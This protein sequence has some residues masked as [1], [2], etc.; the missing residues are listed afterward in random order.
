MTLL[1]TAEDRFS[2]AQA[3]GPLYTVY[4]RV[5]TGP[6][7][8]LADPVQ[9]YGLVASGLFL[10]AKYYEQQGCT[11][12]RFDEEGWF[13]ASDAETGRFKACGAIREEED[14]NG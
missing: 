4:E 11:V 9:D 14:G 6:D 12:E 10:R 13:I 1:R 3:Y 8:A 7:T 2:D 5:G